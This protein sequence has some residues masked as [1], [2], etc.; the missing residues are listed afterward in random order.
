MKRSGK[1]AGI[2]PK[3]SL[4]ITGI[5]IVYFLLIAFQRV[6]QILGSFYVIIGF[7]S[8]ALILGVVSF[9][10]FPA[11]KDRKI[12]AAAAFIALIPLL[13]IVWASY[14]TSNNHSHPAPVSQPMAAVSLINRT[15]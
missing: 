9:V 3:I 4:L 10:L 5:A 6:P 8:A 1:E 14:I 2:L 12:S 15:E 11:K 7:F 13:Y